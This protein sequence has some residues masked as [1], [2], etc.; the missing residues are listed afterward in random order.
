MALNPNAVTA[1]EATQKEAAPAPSVV[2]K[3]AD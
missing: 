3:M 1:A 2:I